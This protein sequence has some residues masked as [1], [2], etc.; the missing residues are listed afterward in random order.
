MNL[1]N[2]LK[3]SESRIKINI[4]AQLI[5]HQK[6]I[7]SCPQNSTTEVTLSMYL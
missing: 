3:D 5:I 7:P 4:F 6:S 2:Y 1:T